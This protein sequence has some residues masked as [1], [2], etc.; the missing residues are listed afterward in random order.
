VLVDCNYLQGMEGDLDSSHSAFLHSRPNN[1]MDRSGADKVRKEGLRHYSFTDKAP[2]FF[3]IQTDAGL[4][5]GAR[6]NADDESYYWRITQWMLPAYSLMPRE[7]GSLRQCNMRIPIDD[8]HHWFYRA[9]YH[10]HRDLTREELYEFREGGNI[11]QEVQRGTYLPTQT[12]ANDFLV[13]RAVQRSGTYSGIKGIPAQDQSVTVTMGP[14]ADRS[15]EHL[16]SADAALIA[17]RR[18]L[19]DSA[20]RLQR[21]STLPAPSSPELYNLRGPACLL[22]KD[23]AFDVGAAEQIWAPRDAAGI[24]RP[25]TGT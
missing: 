12:L 21:G 14:V 10:P 22:P 5:L 1:T 4:M 15:R 24:T 20:R 16:G 2:K 19:L 25:A 9:Q 18:R 7:D 23:V 11:F 13:D 3:T 8:H 17:A 6:R